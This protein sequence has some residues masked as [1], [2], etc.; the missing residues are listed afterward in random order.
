MKIIFIRSRALN[1]NPD[2][3]AEFLLK[4]GFDVK[5]LLWDRQGNYLNTKFSNS[6]VNTFKLKA[7]YDETRIVFYQP[8]WFIYNLFFLLFKDNSDI[9]HAADLDTLISAVLVKLIKEKKAFL[10]NL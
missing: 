8:L 6:I 7:P 2:K 5:L 10:Y 9:I 4:K 3:I 1:G